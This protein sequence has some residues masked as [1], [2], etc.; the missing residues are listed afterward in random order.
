MQATTRVDAKRPKET[1]NGLSKV[2]TETRLLHL[3]TR[4]FQRRL[5]GPT[6]RAL[7]VLLGQQA[8]ELGRAEAELAKRA[9]EIRGAGLGHKWPLEASSSAT[10]GGTMQA[11]DEMVICLAQGHETAARAVRSARRL[12]E[13]AHDLRTC[14]LLARRTNVHEKAAWTL[15]SMY[16]GSLISCELCAARFT[17][18]LSATRPAA[19]VTAVEKC[20]RAQRRG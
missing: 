7:R 19:V 15:T 14:R 17:C 1:A 11:V 2:L 8:D 9:R 16:L 20:A 12:A 6:C 5:V 10:S 18:P 4:D 13:E 3:Q